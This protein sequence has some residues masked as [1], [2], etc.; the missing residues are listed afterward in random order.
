M[1][2][3]LR[4][5]ILRQLR[6]VDDQNAPHIFK[7]IQ[8]EAGYREVENRIIYMVAQEHITPSACIPHIENELQ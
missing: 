7:L 4:T 1:E 8:T 6:K 3:E 5:E 2:E